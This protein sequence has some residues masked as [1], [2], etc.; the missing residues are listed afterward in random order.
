MRKSLLQI[1]Y[2]LK[3]AHSTSDF[4][5]LLL[6]TMHKVLLQK[7][8]GVSSPWKQYTMQ[9]D[10]NDFKTHTRVL[11]DEAPDLVKK[12]EGGPYT[13]ATI[14][15]YKYQIA[16][17]TFGRTFAVTRETIINDDTN[18]LRR[19]LE[20]FGRAS[21][22]SL[23]KQIVDKIEG[24]GNTYDGN[25]MF[26]LGHGNSANTALANTV[27]GRAAVSA[28]MTAI[29]NATDETGEDMGLQAKFLLT[30]TDLHDIAL[31]LTQST[32]VRQVSTS[33]GGTNPG[34][35]RLLTPLKEPFLTSTTSWYV[36]ADPMD[37]PAV[38]VGFLDGKE[39]PDLLLKKAD[40]VRVAG[41]DDEWGY[42]FDDMLF[43]VRFDW[44]T[45]RAM[46]QG[47]YRGKA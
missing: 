40:T 43:K 38:E 8:R 10:M 26:S 27:A 21:V 19:M 12:E 24:D 47:I 23:V 42:E 30:G 33:G 31:Q 35:V 15:D 28:G 1:Y 17:E 44:A 32:E 3:E 36:M 41:G 16:L 11:L 6:N 4:P 18:T 5:N 9:S 37:A 39:E 25:S 14:K 34:V 46:Y 20:K 29:E 2:D 22:R 45:Q 7:F 13:G